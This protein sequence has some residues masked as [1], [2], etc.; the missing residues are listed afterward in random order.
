MGSIENPRSAF[1]YRIPGLLVPQDVVYAKI[2]SSIDEFIN[3]VPEIADRIE[4][5]YDNNRLDRLISNFEQLLT[6]LEDTYAK[7]LLTDGQIILR[8]LVNSG[9]IPKSV[10]LDTFI[11]DLNTLSIEMQKAKSLYK[12]DVCKISAIETHTDVAHNLL[13]VIKL[14]D[15][16][17]YEK[18]KNIISELLD[19]NIDVNLNG[20]FKLC[21]SGKYDEA[22]ALAGVIMEKHKEAISKLKIDMSKK[23]LAVD[24]R[25]EILK[26]VNEALK[27][28]YK[29]FGVGNGITAIKVMEAQQPHLFILDIDMPDMD[30]FELA[31]KI[32]AQKAFAS[33]P[34]IFLTG[35]ASKEHI[36]RALEVGANDF[37]VKPSTHE[38][39]LTKAGKFLAGNEFFLIQ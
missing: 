21:K 10:S 33:T 30:G 32:R 23:I 6:L 22:R 36:E 29:V 12:H 25:P 37:I 24:D 3:C 18:A 5:N 28:H 8:S 13:A 20:L 26:F 2:D 34:I 17:E 38:M 35:N 14:I 11:A 16:D 4:Y 31:E 15:E 1:F 39:L 19:R 9:E 27:M 7:W